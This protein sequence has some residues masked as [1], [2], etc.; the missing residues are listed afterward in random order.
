MYAGLS[1]DDFKNDEEEYEDSD[2]DDDEDEDDDGPDENVDEDELEEDEDALGANLRER[3]FGNK[4]ELQAACF[5]QSGPRLVPSVTE[6]SNTK[7]H[8]VCQE[9][10]KV[11]SEFFCFVFF[12]LHCLFLSHRGLVECSWQ[13]SETSSARHPATECTNCGGA[14][15]NYKCLF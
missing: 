13:T 12:F 10:C 15:E 2:Y 9:G 8:L 11:F 3:L 4:L 14:L 5:L 1:W 6:S 7:V